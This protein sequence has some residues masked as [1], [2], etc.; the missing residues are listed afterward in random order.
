MSQA[1][2]V[3]LSG[4]LGN[5]M[6]QYAAGR[7]L[8]LRLQ[9]PLRLD[10]SWYANR[11]DRKYALA[12]F[13]IHAEIAACPLPVPPLLQGLESRVSRRWSRN[14]SGVPIFREPHFHFSPAFSELVRPVYLEG[15]WQSERYFDSYRDVIAADFTLP[16]ELPQRCLPVQEEIR[17]KDAICLHVRRGD[18][19][20]NPITASV[21]E[22]CSLEYYQQGASLVAGGL[23]NVHGFVFSDDPVWAREH[24][25]VP[26]PTTVVEVN[27][28]D[29][30][31]WDL[32]LMASC[33]RFVIAN[34][35]LSW[36]AAWLGSS[37]DKRVVAPVKWFKTDGRSTI[38]LIP[39]DWTRI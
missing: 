16:G 35:S 38:D 32:H 31:Q 12:D 20:S 1:V 36:W 11:K 22:L 30:A 26:F 14:R 39:A 28:P 17:A 3:G 34:S 19:V 21:H 9:V 23:S 27:G 13:A 37:P 2:I 25:R 33:K 29:E 18:Y 4:G 15:Y 7:A 24:F 8:S 6:F 5:Q 10:L